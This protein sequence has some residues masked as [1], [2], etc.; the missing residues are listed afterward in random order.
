MTGAGSGLSSPGGPP[1]H[2]EAPITERTDMIRRVMLA[3]LLAV[4]PTV[5]LAPAAHAATPDKV[6]CPTSDEC[7]WVYYSNAQHTTET[8][9]LLV[10]CSGQEYRTGTAT[11]YYTYDQEACDELR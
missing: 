3:A 9:T 10:S 8:G 7:I 4:A 1:D 11:S 2:R 6:Y 5:A